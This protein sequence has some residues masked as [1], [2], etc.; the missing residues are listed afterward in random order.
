M[1]PRRHQTVARTPRRFTLEQLEARLAPATLLPGFAEVVV[2]SG[3]SSPTAMEFSP[4]G[5]L[6][7][8]QQAGAMQVSQSGLLLQTNFF[9]DAPVNT[10]AVG[11]RGLLGIAFDPNYA[12]NRFVYVY[13]TTTQAD[14]H[15][16][17]S[18]FTANAAGDL[19]LAGSETVILELD[20]HSAANHNGGAIHFGPDGKLYIGTGENANGSNAQTLTNLHGKV[21]RI[22]ADGTF[23]ADN[24]FVAQTTGKNRAI[25]ALGLRNPFTFAFQPGTGR[26]FINDVGAGAWEEIDN[27]AA[28]ANY[29][30][31]ATEGPFDP[32]SFP[33]FTAPVFAYNHNAAVTTPSGN[34]IAGGAFYNPAVN[35]FDSGSR[36]V[37]DYF[38]ADAGA[39][40]I[41]RYDM[42]TKTVVQFAE[43]ISGPVDLKVD[44]AGNLYYLAIGAGQAFKVSFTGAPPSSSSP[45]LFDPASAA[46]LLRNSNSSGNADQ[47][48]GFGAAGAG[49]LPISG[50]W[51]GD[52]VDSAGVFDPAAS[53]FYLRNAHTTGVSD[54]AFGFGAPGAGWLPIAGDWT[55]NG[56]DTIGLYDP[57]N[58][59]FYLRNSNTAGLADTTFGYGAAGAGLR[60]LAGDWDGNSTTTIGLYAPN[61]S[62][63]YL[64]NSNSTGIANQTFGFGAPQ[65]GWKPLAGDWD[66]VGGDTVG[67]YAPQSATVF[68][69]NSNTTGNADLAFG[70]GQPGSA[71]TPLAGRW[72]PPGAPLLAAGQEPVGSGQTA[73]GS[74]EQSAV[75]GQPSGL[76]PQ[77]LIPSPS[78]VDRIDLPIVAEQ[79]LGHLVG[80]PSL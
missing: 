63:F 55:G 4:D 38:F 58:S 44:A 11:E 16:R 25:W 47:T 7:V 59:V 71:W 76:L 27:G 66:G 13:Y 35:Q 49:W 39:G 54:V 9:R 74:G 5:K 75:S 65:A 43:G 56:S 29:G 8:A 53:T 17:V 50:D 15:N 67:L 42:T 1:S 37:G 32:S 46:F 80:L 12:S 6:F 68:L 62:T 3:L 48:F 45:G 20:P 23:P 21:L 14:S 61:S 28:G 26:L 10:Q 2:A 30:W 22:N 79:E 69:R 52:G 41:Y 73:A 60:P 24:P 77:S 18:R 64:R 70:Y 33:N 72:I 34:V 31:P 19:A 51:D 40:W 36:Y 57:V 78:L